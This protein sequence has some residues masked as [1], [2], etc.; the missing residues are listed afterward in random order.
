MEITT[1]EIARSTIKN[2][3]KSIITDC[4]NVWGSELHYQAIIYH[5]LRENGKIPINQ[6]GMNVKI[7]IDNPSTSLFKSKDLQKK[8]RYRGGF[9]PIPDI[10][11]FD[12]KIDGDWRRRNHENTL[13]QILYA[14]EIKASERKNN[15]LGYSEIKAD[16]DKLIALKEEINRR[17]NK[18]IGIGMLVVDTAKEAHERMKI[19]TLS[20]LIGYSEQHKVDLGYFSL[21]EEQNTFWK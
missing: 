16:I 8:E 9:E 2:A 13:K 3:Y 15:R 12:A 19:E 6:L 5:C 11:I 21:C 18:E 10:V 1:K 17:Y 7:W 20:R 4:R 14:L